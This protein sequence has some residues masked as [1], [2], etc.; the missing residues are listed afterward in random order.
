MDRDF[1]LQAL[2]DIRRRIAREK[3]AAEGRSE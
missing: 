3:A 2:Q 1:E